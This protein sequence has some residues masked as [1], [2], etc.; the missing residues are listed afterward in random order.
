MQLNIQKDLVN[1]LSKFSVQRSALQI[2]N[3]KINPASIPA[4]NGIR[5]LS[6]CWVVMGHAYADRGFSVAI[7]NKLDAYKVCI[8]LNPFFCY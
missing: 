1:T 6:I 4:L 3:I 8:F 2:L 5:F 7:V